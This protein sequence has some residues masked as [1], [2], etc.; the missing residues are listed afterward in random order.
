MSYS[1]TVYA[2]STVTPRTFAVPAATSRIFVAGA[3]ATGQ[4]ERRAIMHGS[5]S[6]YSTSRGA[7]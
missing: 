3:A 5:P 2:A 7:E 4:T 1:P 6:V